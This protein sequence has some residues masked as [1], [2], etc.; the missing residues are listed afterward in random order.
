MEQLTLFEMTT[1]SMPTLDVTRCYTRLVNHAT[2]ANMVERY[3]YAHRVPSIT[4]AV[5]MYVDKVLAGVCTYGTGASP[6]ML[7]ICGKDNSDKV[8]ELN[9]LF[10]HEWA[11][12]NSESWFVAQSFRWIEQTVPRIKVLISY[13]DSAE[14]HTGYIYQ[15]T[16]WLYTGL[17]L[18]TGNSSKITI[19]GQERHSKSFYSELGTQSRIAI[20]QKYPHAV[21]QDYQPKHRYV[22]LLG[23]KREKRALRE[24]LKWPVLPYP[25]AQQTNAE[26]P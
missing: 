6:N 23:N 3:H 7:N 14:N 22:M 18:K 19:D 25:K 21:F 26:N 12:H 13:A 24:A 15:A 16:N 5:G 11:G 9:R 2:A 4:L 10:I 8:W 1:P 20:R 17:S